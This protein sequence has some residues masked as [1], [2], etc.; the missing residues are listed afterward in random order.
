M[1]KQILKQLEP[2]K[3]GD[4]IRVDWLDASRGRM[5]TTREL[6]EMGAAGATIDS[7]VK[8]YGIFIG[9]FGAK[10]KHVVTVASF[11]TFTSVADY[12]QV[13]TMIVPIG[14]VENIA[15]LLPQVLDVAQVR[16]C[17]A[18]FIDGRCRCAQRFRTTKRRIR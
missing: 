7:P 12:G 11:W 9:L 13:D 18:A 10:S 3:P 16:L 1:S 14:C 2:I 8:T 6:R 5:E 4:L 15:V 17:Q